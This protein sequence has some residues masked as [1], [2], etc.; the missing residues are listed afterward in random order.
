MTDSQIILSQ[1]QTCV[2]M[3]NAVSGRRDTMNNIFVTL[4]LAIIATSTFAWSVKSV[5]VLFFLI[6]GVALCFLWTKL[7]KNYKLLNA[8]KFNI[9]LALE[10][11][12]PAQPFFDEWEHLKSNKKYN[13][14]TKLEKALPLIFI[15]VYILALAFIAVNKFWGNK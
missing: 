13:E 14:F 7:I 5:F 10:K 1:W 8:E 15:G 12:L 3:A 4:N 6:V 2:E 9:I 11:Q